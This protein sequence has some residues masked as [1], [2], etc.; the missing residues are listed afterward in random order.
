MKVLEWTF[1][2]ISPFAYLQS[3]QLDRFAKR[4]ELRL[5]PVLFAGLLKHWGTKGPAEL[6]SKRQITY[7]TIAWQAHQHGIALNF[8]AMHPFNPLPLLRL[9]IALGC[10]YDIVQR[11]FRWVWVEGHLPTETEA[12]TQFLAQLGVD[13]AQLESAQVKQALAANT[14]RAI[15][16][17]LFGVPSARC[18]DTASDPEGARAQLFWGFDATAMIEAWLDDVPFFAGPSWAASRSV[19]TG[20]QRRA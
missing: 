3:T 11:A 16:L 13:P 1:D 15:G 17:Q 14:E 6:P 8:P 18:W 9:C 2:V 5:Q 4:A 7:E 19:S 12:W 10:T 20:I